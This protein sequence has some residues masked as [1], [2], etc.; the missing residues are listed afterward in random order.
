MK[1]KI[2]IAQIDIAL[3][4]PKHNQKTVAYYA[5]KAAEVNADVLVY[6]EMWNTGYA[7]TELTNLA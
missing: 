6:P 4:D 5:E 7:L 1:L 3:G 2:A